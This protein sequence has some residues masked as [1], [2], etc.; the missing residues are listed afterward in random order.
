M[1]NFIFCLV[2]LVII[3]V[4]LVST[5][6]I[7]EK[8]GVP[9]WKAIIPFYNVWVLAEIGGKPGWWSLLSYIPCIGI[10]AVVALWMEVCN[11]FNRNRFFTLGIILLPFVFLPMLAFKEDIQYENSDKNDMHESLENINKQVN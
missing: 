1:K 4:N 6:K 9:G 11:K 5:W 3:L 8:A 2:L 10:F 7:Y